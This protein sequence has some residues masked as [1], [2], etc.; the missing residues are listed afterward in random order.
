MTKNYFIQLA[1]YNCWANEIAINWLTEITDNQWNTKLIGSMESIAATT[2]HIAGAEKIWNE[3]IHKS[4]NPFLKY[5]YE[6]NKNGLISIWQKASNDLLILTE[7][8]AESD[9]LNTMTYKNLKG[10]ELQSQLFEILAHVFNHSTYHRGQLVNY[11]R[12]VGYSSVSSTDMINYFRKQ[13]LQL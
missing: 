7:N 3:R 2:T 9:L 12:Q 6:L 11:L 10:E 4:F 1:T 8:I 13:K 5:E